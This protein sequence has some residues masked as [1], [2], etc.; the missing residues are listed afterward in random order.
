[1]DRRKYHREESASQRTVFGCIREAEHNDRVWR[2]GSIYTPYGIVSA[3][4]QDDGYYQFQFIAHERLYSMSGRGKR[5]L[6]KVGLA[7]NAH[8][9]AKRVMQ[10]EF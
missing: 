6:T 2:E 7:R 5:Y 4:S 10:G 1:M 8:K 3:Y 9:F